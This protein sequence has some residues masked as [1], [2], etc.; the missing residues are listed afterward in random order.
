VHSATNFAVLLV[1]LGAS[2]V[3]RR[4]LQRLCNVKAVKGE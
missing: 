3:G 4:L 1:F 2:Q